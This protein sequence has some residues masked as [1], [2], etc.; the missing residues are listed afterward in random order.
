MKLNVLGFSKTNIEI[1]YDLL[2]RDLQGESLEVFLNMDLDI[3]FLQPVK[4]NNIKVHPFGDMPEKGVKY[5]FGTSGPYNKYKIFHDF[6]NSCFI[7]RDSYTSVIHSSAYIAPS[8]AIQSGAFIEANATVCSQTLIGFGVNI[9]RGVQVGHHNIIGEFTD[10]NPGV[11]LSGSINVGRG[12][13]LGTGALL[14]NNITIG[15][16]TIIGMGSVVTKDIPS[17]VVAYG[18]PC[19]VVSDN[20]KYRI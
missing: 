8:S 10:I 12:C 13:T 17:G 16:N 9:K 20:E 15:D 3:E 7:D 11:V 5:I 19:K 14:R 1:L 4:K 6:L 2:E 18:N